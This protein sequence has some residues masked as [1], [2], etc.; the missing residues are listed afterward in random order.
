MLSAVAPAAAPPGAQ[1]DMLGRA[2]FPR[3]S[4]WH[5]RLAPKLTGMLLELDN[6]TLL[7]LLDS[8]TLLHEHVSDALRA[9]EGS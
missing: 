5:P 8:D 7:D 2:L 9:F 4:L 3:I 1:K 6:R